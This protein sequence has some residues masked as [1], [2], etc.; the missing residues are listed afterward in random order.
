[1]EETK[2]LLSSSKCEGILNA[3]F[4]LN[5]VLTAANSPLESLPKG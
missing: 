3:S 4:V 2:D 1:M 5:H